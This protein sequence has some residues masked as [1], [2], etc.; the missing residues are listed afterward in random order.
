[1]RAPR[2]ARNDN[3]GVCQRLFETLGIEAGEQIFFDRV[4]D[5]DGIAADFTIFDVDLAGNGEV[6][7]HGDFFPAVGAHELVFHGR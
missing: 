2:W 1:M 7:E 3:G 5:L 4:A 6:Q